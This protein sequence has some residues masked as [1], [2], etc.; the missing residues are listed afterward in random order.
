[1][2]TL[3]RNNMINTP[4]VSNHR[5]MGTEWRFSGTVKKAPKDC[6]E[7]K[8]LGKI[9]NV[10]KQQREIADSYISQDNG[11]NDLDP[12]K[13]Y[14]EMEKEVKIRPHDDPKTGQVGRELIASGGKEW[15]RVVYNAKTGVPEALNRR[16]N[17]TNHALVSN[18]I[19]YSGG[20]SDVYFT[21]KGNIHSM[22]EERGHSSKELWGFNKEKIEIS[23]NSDGSRSYRES[24]SQV[25][26]P[27][28]YST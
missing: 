24:N 21:K 13:G 15:V 8:T 11:P 5:V 27:F 2:N 19:S 10:T 22:K 12:R 4:D 18:K 9:N 17:L 26:I 3:N 23:T 7:C 14:V 1:M 16:I 6:S 20:S 25:R 28:P